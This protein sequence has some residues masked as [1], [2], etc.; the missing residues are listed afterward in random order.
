M[1]AL[2]AFKLALQALVLVANYLHDNKMMQA[3]AHKLIVESIERAS[4]EVDNAIFAG[5]HAARRFDDND[6]LPD[7]TDP[8]LRD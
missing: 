6:G 7:N 3:G 4:D 1:S 5:E 8:N 2:K